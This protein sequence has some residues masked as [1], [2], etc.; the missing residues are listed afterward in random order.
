M[1]GAPAGDVA[2][3]A[4]FSPGAVDGLLGEGEAAS[5]SGFWLR[6]SAAGPQSPVEPTAPAAT[7]PSGGLA[8]QLARLTDGRF[9]AVASPSA[10]D[11]VFSELGRDRALGT[12]PAD[13]AWTDVEDWLLPM[14]AEENAAG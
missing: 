14:D 3:R 6:M 5:D 8:G 2:A 4:A 9:P 1:P 13:A 12:S 11:R 7:L 10:R